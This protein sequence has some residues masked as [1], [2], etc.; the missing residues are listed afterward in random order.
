LEDRYLPETSAVFHYNAQR[1]A[2]GFTDGIVRMTDEDSPFR[3]VGPTP[4]ALTIA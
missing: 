2:W 3:L 4:L 1:R